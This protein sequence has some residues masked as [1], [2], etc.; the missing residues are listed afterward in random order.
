M[1][2]MLNPMTQEEINNLIQVEKKEMQHGFLKIRM[3]GQGIIL[4][5]II[6]EFFIVR[7]GMAILIMSMLY[8]IGVFAIILPY[9]LE[10]LNLTAINFSKHSEAN[11]QMI[12]NCY[13]YI[14]MPKMEFWKEYVKSVEA[15]N[16]SLTV[17][18]CEDIV[19]AWNKL[20]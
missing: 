17:K 9:M 10:F 2:A 20:I 5:A 15:M 3:F 6:C 7:E 4:L 16:R 12:H 13:A 19:E 14:E 1:N 18:E 11:K 8:A